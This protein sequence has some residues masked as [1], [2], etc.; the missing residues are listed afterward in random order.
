[1]IMVSQVFDCL[2]EHA[3]VAAQWRGGRLALLWK[4]KGDSVICSNS[5]GILIGDD[6]GKLSTALLASHL[7]CRVDSYFP[8][9]QCG[10]HL[11]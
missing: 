1:M 2:S 5:R 7:S 9:E 4:K 10:G 6:C 8:Q 11:T 3:R